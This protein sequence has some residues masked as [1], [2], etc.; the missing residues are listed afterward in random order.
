MTDYRSVYESRS[1]GELLRLKEAGGL[2]P[3]AEEALDAVLSTRADLHEVTERNKEAIE[4]KEPSTIRRVA[5]VIGCIAYTILLGLVYTF[6]RTSGDQPAYLLIVIAILLVILTAG[7][8]RR[9]RLETEDLGSGDHTYLRRISAI[10]LILLGAELI[11]LLTILIGVVVY[12]GIRY[13]FRS[14]E[15]RP[16]NTSGKPG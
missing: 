12:Q 13:F 15:D 2:R 4:A 1:T 3:E 9:R 11:G 7:Y 14:R 6:L 10:M 8:I 5:Y 16:E